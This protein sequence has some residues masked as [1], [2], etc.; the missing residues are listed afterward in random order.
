LENIEN[1]NSSR[2]GASSSDILVKYELSDSQSSVAIDI[3]TKL[4]QMGKHTSM[5]VSTTDKLLSDLINAS[6]SMLMQDALISSVQ[7]YQIQMNKVSDLKLR[8]DYLEVNE[9][10]SY[11]IWPILMTSSTS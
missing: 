2:V 4:V 7:Q 10:K 8:S 3:F 11:E 5:L 1:G 9:S 6:K